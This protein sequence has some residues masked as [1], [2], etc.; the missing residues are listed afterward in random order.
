MQS[1]SEVLTVQEQDLD[2]NQHVNNVRYVEWV[3]NISKK[4]W[5]AAT[6]PDIRKNM[7]WV[8]KN[9]NISYQ[10]SA[11]LGDELLLKTHIQKTQGPLSIRVVEIHHNK[12]G[13]LIVK[14]ITEWCLLDAISLRP[15]RVPEAIQ[16]LFKGT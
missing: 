2:D 8:V 14:A 12:T 5:E 7:I 16:K 9:H 11:L 15:K 10:R 4:H 1:Y 3:Q 13:Q 6:N